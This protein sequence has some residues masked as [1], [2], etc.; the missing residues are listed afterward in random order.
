MLRVKDRVVKAESFHM[1]RLKVPL[2]SMSLSILHVYHQSLLKLEK[3][4]MLLDGEIL[5][6]GILKRQKN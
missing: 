6:N 5:M 3:D 4:V 2:I 1:F